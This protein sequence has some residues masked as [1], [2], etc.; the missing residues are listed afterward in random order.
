MS[1]RE[2]ED[3]VFARVPRR[4]A[5]RPRRALARGLG[6]LDARA[7]ELEHVREIRIVGPDT[8]LRLG[9]AGRTLAAGLRD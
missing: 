7:G 9:V 4:R 2:Y 6:E 3:F 5:T 8:D 1:L